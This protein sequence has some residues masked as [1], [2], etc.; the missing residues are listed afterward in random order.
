MDQTR[1]KSIII[2]N[3]SLNEEIELLNYHVEYEFS[4]CFQ[5]IPIEFEKYLSK[6]DKKKK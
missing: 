5:M 1:R 2:S 4:L 3:N 6:T